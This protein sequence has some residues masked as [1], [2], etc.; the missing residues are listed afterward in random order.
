MTR[1]EL[2][3]KTEELQK[4]AKLGL[5]PLLVYV[6]LLAIF[7]WWA[8]FHKNIIPEKMTAAVFVIGFVGIYGML[9][10]I[11]LFSKRRRQ[12]LGF[13]CPQCKKELFGRSL[14]IA[15]ASERCGYCGAIVLEDW[16]K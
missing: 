8:N 16:N 4:G 10:I 3:K 9:F 12:Q 7:L 11:A 13:R 6:V 15:I 14:E 2:V 5:L 1:A